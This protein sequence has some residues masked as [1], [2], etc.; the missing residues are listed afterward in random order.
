M[1]SEFVEIDGDALK[2]LLRSKQLTRFD[3]AAQLSVST[4]TVQRWLNHTIMKV[5]PETVERIGG[6]LDVCPSTIRRDLPNLKIRPVNKALAEFC[7]EKHF[8]QTRLKDTWSSYRQVLKGVKLETLP[9]EQQMVVC[10]NIGISSFYLGKFRSAKLYLNKSYKIAESL[11]KDEIRANILVWMARLNETLGEFP[12]ALSE[13]DSSAGFFS[14]ETRLSIVAEHSYVLGRVHMHQGKND[15]AILELR[16]GILLSYQQRSRDLGLLIAWSYVM[17]M[18]IYLRVKDYSQ[19]EVTVR[20]LKRTAEILGWS[21]GLLL[22]NYFQGML[23]VFTGKSAE[24][25]REY[26]GKARATQRASQID[27]FCPQLAQAEFIYFVLTG[28]YD[29]AR[30]SMVQRLYKTRH[31]THLWAAAVL[32]GV[33]LAKV[34]PGMNTVRASMIAAAKEHFELHQVQRPL[35]LLE[36]LQNRS[37]VSIQEVSDF[38]YF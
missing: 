1:G 11:S 3:L 17:L 32:D 10:R 4:K 29:E 26:F 2:E 25:S 23:A 28:R 20:R 7:S 36:Q 18:Y 22:T 31:A 14:E 19:A 5:K 30:V 38:Y 8:D 9:S 37:E 24:Q 35:Q 27:R 34:H 21:R 16:R 13:L 12:K 15:E 6:V 33:L